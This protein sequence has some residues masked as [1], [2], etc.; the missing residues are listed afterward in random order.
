METANIVMLVQ[1][2]IYNKL[3]NYWAVNCANNTM[4]LKPDFIY[5]NTEKHN[6]SHSKYTCL[7]SVQI[8]LI[9]MMQAAVYVTWYWGCSE[10][11]GEVKHTQRL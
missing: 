10:V 6:F 11:Q 4:G 7:C 1:T 5:L 3:L 2:G 9:Y 8:E